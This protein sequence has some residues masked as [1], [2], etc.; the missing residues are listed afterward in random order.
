MACPIS[1]DLTEAR[2]QLLPQI[3]LVLAWFYYR[4][5]VRGIFF[6]PDKVSGK[7]VKTLTKS[8][9]SIHTKETDTAMYITYAFCV[10]N[11]FLRVP[12]K[13]SAMLK[14]GHVGPVVVP[15]WLSHTFAHLLWSERPA[16]TSDPAILFAGIA[17]CIIVLMWCFRGKSGARDAIQAMADAMAIWF[18]HCFFGHLIYF[19]C[20]RLAL[21]TAAQRNHSIQQVNEALENLDDHDLESFHKLFRTSRLDHNHRQFSRVTSIIFALMSLCNVSQWAIDMTGVRSVCWAQ[22]FWNLLPIAYICSHGLYP[23]IEKDYQRKVAV[24][25]ARAFVSPHHAVWTK[26]RI[27]RVEN[28]LELE[29]TPTMKIVVWLNL[30]VELPAAV[31]FAFPYLKQIL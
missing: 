1:D 3:C 19:A 26:Q 25:N 6:P 16:L 2:V 31:M 24:A 14:S 17:L 23:S 18:T 11:I 20:A 5:K 22:H 30:S 9:P 8:S 7:I 15:S 21:A 4:H 29:R 13:G 10:I 28:L 12:S 27:D